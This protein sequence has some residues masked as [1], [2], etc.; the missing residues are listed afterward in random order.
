MTPR[1]R[2][3]NAWNRQLSAYWKQNP[4]ETC[5]V[6]FEG[7]FGTYGLGPAHSLRRFKIRTK[8]EFFEVVAACMKCHETL[9]QKMTPEACQA[10]VR[11]I[12]HNR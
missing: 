1:K 10:K 5:E 12:I 8:E 9:D 3:H 4:I 6:R 2:Q 11:E 7:C